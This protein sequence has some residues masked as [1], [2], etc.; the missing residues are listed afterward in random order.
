MRARVRAQGY[1]RVG[2]SDGFRAKDCLVFSF[3]A[4]QGKYEN[5]IM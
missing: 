2:V 5:T 4:I 1:V 3:R